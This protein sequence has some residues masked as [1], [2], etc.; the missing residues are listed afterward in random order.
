MSPNRMHVNN[1]I[2]YKI[3]KWLTRKFHK[4]DFIER[5]IAGKQHPTDESGV[6]NRQGDPAR[7]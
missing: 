4:H 6:V 7:A 1:E 3:P 2:K 5:I